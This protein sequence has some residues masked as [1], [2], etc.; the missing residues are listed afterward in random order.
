MP[1]P[2]PSPRCFPKVCSVAT[3]SSVVGVAACAWPPVWHLQ[4]CCLGSS[5]CR[6]RSQQVPPSRSLLPRPPAFGQS[7]RT[8]VPVEIAAST[9]LVAEVCTA[10]YQRL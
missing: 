1:A 10:V 3:S 9:S 8:S 2:P 6:G 4:F 7:S 5:G